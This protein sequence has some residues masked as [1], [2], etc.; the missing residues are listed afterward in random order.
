MRTWRKGNLL[1][2]VRIRKWWT[3]VKQNYK[4]ND[5]NHEDSQQDAILSRFLNIV[6]DKTCYVF[7]RACA[8][9]QII[10][11]SLLLPCFQDHSN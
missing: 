11:I 5:C 8:H 9:T 6:L 1:E 3:E 10:I 4:P 7:F 2:H